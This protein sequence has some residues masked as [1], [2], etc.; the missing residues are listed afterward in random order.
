MNA[1]GDAV[2]GLVKSLVHNTQRKFENETISSQIGF[3]FEELS[4]RE[5]I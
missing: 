2:G 4:S 1:S 5:I 3:A